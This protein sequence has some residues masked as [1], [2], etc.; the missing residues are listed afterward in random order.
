MSS[1]PVIRNKKALYG[2]PS[3]Y[4]IAD[5]QTCRS[6]NISVTDFVKAAFEGGAR[7]V[8]YRDKR[9]ADNLELRSNWDQILDLAQKFEATPVINDYPGLAREYG[10]MAHF[11]QDIEE[12]LSGFVFGRSTHNM[13]EVEKACREPVEP[14]YIGL[15]AAFTTSLKPNIEVL[16]SS[17]IEEALQVWKKEIVFIGGITINNFTRLPSGD[18]F[19]YAVISDVFSFGSKPPDIER[20]TKAFLQ[21]AGQL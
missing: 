18:R 7:L 10:S 17:V 16:S 6:Q 21:K 2:L 11:G 15:G 5:F 4:V 13:V 14:A 1:V 9:G 12:E 19:F 3:L 20:Y 8:Q